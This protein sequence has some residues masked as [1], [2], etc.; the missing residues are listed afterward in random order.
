MA[1]MQLEGLFNSFFTGPSCTWSCVRRCSVL[2]HHN[3]KENGTCVLPSSHLGSKPKSLLWPPEQHLLGPLQKPTYMPRPLG[4]F[5][6]LSSLCSNHLLPLHSLF[7]QLGRHFPSNSYF[8][9]P[10]LLQEAPKCHLFSEA[11]PT[12]PLPCFILFPLVHITLW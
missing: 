3:C 7:P 12:T 6:H 11:S 5:A 2:S 1:R 9:I 8:F 4:L 10:W